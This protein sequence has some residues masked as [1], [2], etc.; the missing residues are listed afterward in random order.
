MYTW[1]QGE[2]ATR[3]HHVPDSREEVI[4]S[5]EMASLIIKSEDKNV[6]SLIVE[7]LQRWEDKERT[8]KVG[9]GYKHSISYNTHREP[10]DQFYMPN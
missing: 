5:K 7:H 1:L 10:A 6:T 4:I 8:V 2:K 3:E 9:P